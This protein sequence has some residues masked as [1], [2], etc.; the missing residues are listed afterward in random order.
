[1]SGIDDDQ[2]TVL[3]N[4]GLLRAQRHKL[5]IQRH[6]ITRSYIASMSHTTTTTTTTKF[7]HGNVF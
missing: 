6:H 4:F 3:A 7:L 5:G 1:V 2:P